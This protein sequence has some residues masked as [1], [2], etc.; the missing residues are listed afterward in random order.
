MTVVRSYS[1]DGLT[2]AVAGVVVTPTVAPVNLLISGEVPMNG[3]T[4]LK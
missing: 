1:V 4:Y 2:V 3:I